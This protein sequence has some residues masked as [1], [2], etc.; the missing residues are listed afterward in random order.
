MF[1]I[2]IKLSIFVYIFCFHMSSGHFL[3]FIS[4]VC[5]LKLTP[6]LVFKLYRILLL[7][8]VAVVLQTFFLW[9]TTLVEGRVA[10]LKDSLIGYLSIIS[11]FFL[12]C[13]AELFTYLS[14]NILR[15][16]YARKFDT[17]LKFF[18][19]FYWLILLLRFYFFTFLTSVLFVIS[20]KMNSLLLISS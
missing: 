15:N 20:L 11:L 3:L 14:V 5:A 19:Y 9:L 16:L 8:S 1:V 12:L 13:F 10:I 6:S 18:C 4:V 17:F 7:V 2:D